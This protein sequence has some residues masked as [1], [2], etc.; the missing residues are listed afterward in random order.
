MKAIAIILSVAI[1]G[2]AN[3][4][5]NYRPIVDTQNTS[6][7]ERDLFECQA[8]ASQTADAAQSA[9]AGAV[10]GAILGAAFAAIVGNGV[11]RNQVAGVGALSGAVQ[12]GARGE[13]NQRDIIRRCLAGRGYSVLQ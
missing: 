4:G 5:Q 8:Y 2:C 13:T 11:S 6:Q 10:A 9:M 1:A 3:T 7:Y 12:G